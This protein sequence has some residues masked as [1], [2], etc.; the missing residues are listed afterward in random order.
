MADKQF[1]SATE[2]NGVAKRS[3]SLGPLPNSQ[4]LERLEKIAPGSAEKIIDDIMAESDH[5]RSLEKKEQKEYWHSRK[6][7][8]RAALFVAVAMIGCTF[9]LVYFGHPIAGT[10]FGGTTFLSVVGMFIN[11]KDEQSENEDN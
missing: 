9:S 3:L 6:S 2:E 5:R 8:N 7:G 4:E 10:L 1:V 11:G